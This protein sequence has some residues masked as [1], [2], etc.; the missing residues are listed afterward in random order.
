MRSP[1]SFLCFGLSKPRDPIHSSY[2][3]HSRPAPSLQSSLGGSPI[4]L[5]PSYIVVP[6]LVPSARGEAAQQRG[7]PL[8][9]PAG[10]AEPEVLQSVVGPFG[11]RP[12][13]WLRFNLPTARAPRPLSMGMFSSLSSCSL[14]I[15]PGLPH[16]SCRIQHLLLSNFMQLVTAQ[17]SDLS[18]HPCSA[19]S[20]FYFSIK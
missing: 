7:Q 6:T 16:P 8:S 12:H 17:P 9:L 15:L 18:R 2:V 20:T 4:V 3:L 13:C 10:S 14:Y 1:I 19:D 5:S 11:S